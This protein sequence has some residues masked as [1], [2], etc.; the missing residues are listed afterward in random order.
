MR[1]CIVGTGRCGTTLLWQM[2]DLHPEVYVFRESHWIPKMYELFGTGQGSAADLVD[3]VLRTTFVTGDL[4]FPGEDPMLE[5]LFPVPERIGVAAFCNRIGT[6]LARREGKQIWADKTPDYGPYMQ[7]LQTLWPSCRFIHL[8][9]NGA[10]VTRSMSGHPGFRWMASAGE[11]W[12]VSASFNEYHRSIEVEDR[13]LEEYGALWY[14]R[15][16]RIRNEAERLLPGTYKEVRFEDLL[17]TPE[18]VLTQLSDF[19]GL[20]VSEEWLRAA[21]SIV[22]YERFEGREP[23]ESE[24][25]LTEEQLHLMK[26][27]GYL[28]ENDL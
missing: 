11:S 21:V 19:V 1:F 13:P 23:V 27:L 12:W 3:I 5:T 25:V 16:Q 8:I 2:M 17:E 28:D 14:R 6:E 9:R 24:S 4:V 18:V 22:D 26:E 7:M 20:E 10:E 15:L